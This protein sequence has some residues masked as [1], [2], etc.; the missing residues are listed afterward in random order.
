MKA[1]KKAGLFGAIL[2]LLFF[3]YDS[4]HIIRISEGLSFEES[5]LPELKILFSNTILFIAPAVVLF[6]I[7]D[8][9]QKYI[10]TAW[11][12]PIILGLG[13]VNVLISND[14]LA[15]GLPMV[16]L[17]FPACVI[18]AVLYFFLREKK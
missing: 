1:H 9:K 17:V 2:V 10:F 4:Y 13:L 14:A 16:L 3:C 6:L 12:Y 11:L 7:E 18:L 5:L 15:A 8:F